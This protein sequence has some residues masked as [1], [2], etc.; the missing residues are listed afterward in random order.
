[1]AVLLITMLTA[2]VLLVLFYV[3]FGLSRLFGRH[4]D[5]S[6]AS[7]TGKRRGSDYKRT[8]APA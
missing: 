8:H 7:R 5:Q 6:R 3:A 4:R 2:F 1:M